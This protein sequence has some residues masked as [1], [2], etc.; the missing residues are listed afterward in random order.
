[1]PML[2]WLRQLF[3][4]KPQSISYSQDEV[5]YK[6]RQWELLSGVLKKANT[7]LTEAQWWLIKA[8]VMSEFDRRIDFAKSV[9]KTAAQIDQERVDAL[10]SQFY[11]HG[12]IPPEDDPKFAAWLNSHFKMK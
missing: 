11:T 7:Q 8:K 4:S 6:E 2:K 3:N 12:I 5:A 10:N 1:M 9:G